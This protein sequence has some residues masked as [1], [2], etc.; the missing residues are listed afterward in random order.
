MTAKEGLV[1]KAPAVGH[2][3][4]EFFDA[5]VAHFRENRLGEAERCCRE[6]LPE[7]PNNGPCLDLIGNAF[8]G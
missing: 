5:A 3:A 4:T 1:M 7:H 2:S 6:Q 8:V